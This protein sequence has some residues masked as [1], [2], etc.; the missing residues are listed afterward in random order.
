MGQFLMESIFLSLVALTLGIVIL[1]LLLPTFSNLVHLDL[2]VK[3]FEN[4]L[5]IP[6]LLILVIFVGVLSGS[7]PAF[8]LSSFRPLAVLSGKLATGMKTG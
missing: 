4:P 8:Y 6:S 1:E 3:Y 2:R 5:I 7:Y